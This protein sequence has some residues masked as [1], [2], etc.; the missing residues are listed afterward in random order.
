[1]E[2][3]EDILRQDGYLIG[4]GLLGLVNGMEFSPWFE[5]GFVLLRPLLTSFYLSSP[6]LTLY[7]TSL[8]LAVSS[9]IV[10]GVPAAIFERMTG[11]T[12]SDGV[13]MSIWLV[14]MFLL[15]VPS[16][17]RMIGAR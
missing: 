1:M 4:V 12:Q 10:S 8:F 11:R 3:R 15:T 17:L 6:L 9:V 7:F 5:P 13:S 16:L 2:N 14:A